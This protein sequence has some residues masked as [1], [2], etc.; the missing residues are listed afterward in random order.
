MTCRPGT[1]HV[2]F[3]HELLLLMFS[4][5]LRLA[6]PYSP[7]KAP[8]KQHP[9]R[10]SCSLVSCQ[11]TLCPHGTW[12][13]SGKTSGA[14]RLGIVFAQRLREEELHSHCNVFLPLFQASEHVFSFNIL[15]IAVKGMTDTSEQPSFLH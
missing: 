15:R 12:K 11:S 5:L 13:L 6:D 4:P 8:L 14:L 1:W 7:C 2:L 9:L 10:G 3:N